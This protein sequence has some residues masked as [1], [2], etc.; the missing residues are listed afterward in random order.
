MSI[1]ALLH[2][3]IAIS[4]FILAVI[5]LVMYF[6]GHKKVHTELVIPATPQQ[7]WSV[8]S[9]PSG[10]RQWNPVLIPIEGEFE[11]GAKLTYEM[12]QPDGKKSIVQAKVIEII[13]EKKLN[14]YGGILGILTFDHTYLLEAVEGGTK[15][16]QHEEYRGIG[17][18]FWN[19]AWVEVA[20]QKANESLKNKV[21][22]LN[23]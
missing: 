3:K 13:P 22:N 20:Y 16:T 21:I 14:Q 17:V 7:V 1:T 12:I 15:I 2:S 18:L 10:F 23:K 9:D 5:L 4:L 8:L 11:K 6:L 19:P